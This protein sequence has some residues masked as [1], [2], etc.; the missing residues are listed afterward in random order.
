MVAAGDPEEHDA[1][2]SPTYQG[3]NAGLRRI[4]QFPE[5]SSESDSAGPRIWLALEGV[6]DPMNLGAVMRSAYFLG[7]ERVVVSRKSRF[8]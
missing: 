4:G 3:I 7:V 8:V 5:E 2:F 1:A 6:L